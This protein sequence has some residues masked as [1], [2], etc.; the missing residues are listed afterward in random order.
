MTSRIEKIKA[1]LNDGGYLSEDEQKLLDILKEIE[2]GSNKVKI[3]QS[4]QFT[5]ELYSHG[6]E[7]ISLCSQVYQLTCLL[8]KD[9]KAFFDKLNQFKVQTIINQCDWEM[10]NNI[11]WYF[12]TLDHLFIPDVFSRMSA[13]YLILEIY[14]DKSTEQDILHFHNVVYDENLKQV[15]T[16][17]L[18]DRLKSEVNR[19]SSKLK[20]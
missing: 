3:I 4:E 17:I 15:Y 20:P 8:R 13:I 18:N 10:T 11:Y 6:M 2:K 5:K 12:F 9:K 1:I 7:S 16:D 14:Y 19:L